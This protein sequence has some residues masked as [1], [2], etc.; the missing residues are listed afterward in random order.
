[1]RVSYAGFIHH[2]PVSSGS[3]CD[4]S[5]VVGYVRRRYNASTS[6]F[7]VAALWPS[8]VGSILVN[9]LTSLTNHWCEKSFSKWLWFRWCLRWLNLHG[10]NGV[11]QNMEWDISPI[12]SFVR[13]EDFENVP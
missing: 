7:A 10:A 1:M 4:E 3:S 13:E 2:G 12:T 11:R 6:S 8:L 9:A 5:K